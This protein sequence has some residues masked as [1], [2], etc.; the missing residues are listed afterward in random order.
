LAQNTDQITKIWL[1]TVSYGPGSELGFHADLTMLF[2]I[3]IFNK[4]SQD[5]M[6]LILWS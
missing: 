4:L 1:L 2:C 5:W 6:L 3:F